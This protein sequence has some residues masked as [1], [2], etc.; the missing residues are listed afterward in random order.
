MNASISAR[1]S[2]SLYKLASA[3]EGVFLSIEDKATDCYRFWLEENPLAVFRPENAAAI[4][5]FCSACK[6]EGFFPMP[7]C[8]GTGIAKRR[9]DVALILTGHLA[10]ISAYEKQE[11][12]ITVGPGMTP[13]RLN[14]LVCYD[15]W[16]FPLEM[17]S[18]DVAGLGGCLSAAARS[19]N[20]AKGELLTDLFTEA[21]IVD[22]QGVLRR[23]DPLELYGAHGE[24]GTIVQL[25]VQLKP[26]PW[27]KKTLVSAIDL[28]N[29]LAFLPFFRK[30][31]AIRS[32]VWR[33]PWLLVRLEGEAWRIEATEE[34]MRQRFAF[35]EE[36]ENLFF[37]SLGRQRG[38]L[39]FLEGSLSLSS[40]PQ[41]EKKLQEIAKEI[42]LQSEMAVQLLNGKTFLLLRSDEKDPFFIEK[43]ARFRA[44]WGDSASQKSRNAQDA[45]EYEKNS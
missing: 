37:F 12:R 29:A 9:E 43:I 28:E 32:V 18:D 41:A 24:K 30:E 11:G 10:E 16:R 35:R 15:G 26:I 45:G 14:R 31:I 22:K 3:A 17:E 39:F 44:S 4:A 42:G 23:E 8:G 34:D 21:W 1:R 33:R 38:K 13:R 27:V 36:K 5:P 6:R 40:L 20:E 7:Y 25:R 19:Y 2:L